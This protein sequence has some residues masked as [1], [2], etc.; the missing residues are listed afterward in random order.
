MQSVS[1]PTWL[2]T[3]RDN[4]YF[5]R[6]FTR[7]SMWIQNLKITYKLHYNMDPAETRSLLRDL[8]LTLQPRVPPRYKSWLPLATQQLRLRSLIQIIGYNLRTEGKY[9]KRYFYYTIHRT[10]MSSP[11]YTSE[12][13]DNT[14]PRWACLEVPT[15]HATG[16]SAASEIVLRLWR[17][18][19]V[20]ATTTDVVVFA[21]G[22]SFTGLAYI[23]PK[24][25]M[26]LQNVLKDNS[27]IFHLHGGFFTPSYCLVNTPE[28][29]R[30]LH[31]NVNAS[32][33]R[34]SY[35]VNKLS[36]LR[37][38]MQ[39]LKQQ[40]ESVR[41]LRERIASGE[42]IQ[43]QKYPH[44]SLNRLLQPKRLTREKKIEILRIKKDLEVAKFRTKLLEQERVRK[45][46]ELRTLNQLHA[47]IL[48]TNQDH[49]SD[50]MGRYRE[51]NRDIER[52]REWKQSHAETRETFVQT[53][54]QLAYRRRQL[55]S[56]LDLIYPITREEDGKFMINDV[57]LPD[58]E[59]LDSSNDTQVAVALGSVAHVTLMIANFLN[60]PTRYPIIHSGSR[61][62]I[63]DHI[64]DSLPD[65]DRQFPLFARGK[66]KLQFHYA[67]YLL[68][69]NIAQ[70][71][72]YCGLPTVDLR[73]TLMNLTSLINVKPNQPLDSSKRTFSGSSL[74]TEM[75]S[76][77]HNPPLTPPF[78]KVIF[79][80]CHRSARSISQLKSVKSS[81][82]SSLD[83]GLDRPI[84]SMNLSR[85]SKRIF[86]SEE[87]AIDEK[88][89]S[90]PQDR[91][92]NSSNDTL[93]E[94]IFDRNV[95]SESRYRSKTYIPDNKSST[96]FE[97]NIE[98]SIPT[99]VTKPS[100]I[101]DDFE[102]SENTAEP[103]RNSARA[104][105]RS[106]N[107]ISSCEMALSANQLDVDEC[108]NGNRNKP[109]E[110]NENVFLKNNDRQKNIDTQ[111]KDEQC[112][113]NIP[114]KQNLLQIT[115]DH[116]ADKA[117]GECT[118]DAF[119]TSKISNSCLS[120]DGITNYTNENVKQKQRT[121]SVSSYP[122]DLLSTRK[123]PRRRYDSESRHDPEETQRLLSNRCSSS[124][125]TSSEE[126]LEHL[127]YNI[128]MPNKKS[129]VTGQLSFFSESN[130]DKKSNDLQASSEYI[131]SVRRSSE[132][133]FAR[134]EAL[135]KKNTSFKVMRPRM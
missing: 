122:E 5:M 26:N 57:H 118:N 117:S 99:S 45:M 16:H 128:P 80:K 107:S 101:S 134:T 49:G 132:N 114:G 64:T 47:S 63:I 84:Q 105:Q 129:L 130:D 89:F 13:I 37:S 3:A 4:T 30:Y 85:E 76:G 108:S 77:K 25:S 43:V 8:D 75:S 115:E 2:N 69:K 71:R 19:V 41:V 28:P 88:T 131:D 35:T 59:E 7:H 15:L 36:S 91:F 73:T 65:K 42:D 40:S 20:D 120:L 14:S 94:T 103:L 67:V 62:K 12:P 27:L 96:V 126:R 93:N 38:K 55:V 33:I 110:K 46:G 72:W 106:S 68:N 10:N 11:L 123:V 31:I 39:A 21:W 125:E 100:N 112:A 22:I 95:I 119:T 32:E 78:Q 124:P 121:G 81:L 109:D 44:S 61:S 58:S 70:L 86:K 111:Y 116:R 51:L 90:L 133:V 17:R 83:Q 74:D 66:D 34:D 24:L 6:N 29:K 127:E 104:R 98:I 60:V 87:S 92:S 48:E 50:L 53:T 18:T 82:G 54:G 1:D 23:G 56:E 79:E 97:S 113:R 52:L 102:N 9:E 135:A